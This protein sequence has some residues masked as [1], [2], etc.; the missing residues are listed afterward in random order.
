MISHDFN[1]Q[2]C[3][4]KRINGTIV[5]FTSSPE[6][7]LE[8]SRYFLLPS[9]LQ[10]R[11]SPKTWLNDVNRSSNPTILLQLFWISRSQLS[12]QHQRPSMLLS[13]LAPMLQLQSQAPI[14]LIKTTRQPYDD[15]PRPRLS[16][17]RMFESQDEK[18]VEWRRRI[19]PNFSGI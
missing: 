14:S 13:L 19:F 5:I 10:F 11:L 9:H 4:Q 1:R 3:S 12:L 7:S 15:D 16:L 17:L 8:K 6:C 18:N 2:I